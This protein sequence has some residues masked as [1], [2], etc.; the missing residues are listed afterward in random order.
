MGTL[1]LSG[2]AVF[3]AGANKSTALV[4]A[5]YDYAILQAEAL[6]NATSR[7]NWVDNYATL[8][9]D[10]KYFLEQLCSDIAGSYLINYDP[11]TYGNETATI[12]LDFLRDSIMRGLS[13]LRDK[14]TQDFIN[15]A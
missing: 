7:Y 10:I 4:E 3:K 5:D 14:K 12:K 6:I 15:G 13:I 1:C 8:N 11:T 9:V 2:A